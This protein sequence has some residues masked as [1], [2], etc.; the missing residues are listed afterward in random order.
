MS[1]GSTT[2]IPLSHMSQSLKN[3]DREILDVYFDGAVGTREKL[4]R[5]CGMMP[6]IN[7]DLLESPGVLVVRS[8]HPHLY[9]GRA[10][11]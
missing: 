4:R 8:I 5:L 9:P 6:E 10:I 2:F 7:R 1:D 3:R 11:Q